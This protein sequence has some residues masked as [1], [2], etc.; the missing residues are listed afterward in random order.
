MREQETV[1]VEQ[2]RI[3]KDIEERVA[4][5]PIVVVPNPSPVKVGISGEI[6]R[7]AEEAIVAT[8]RLFVALPLFLTTA[9]EVLRKRLFLVTTSPVLVRTPVPALNTVLL[10]N[11]RLDELRGCPLVV[12]ASKLRSLKI[13][14]DILTMA[15]EFSVS[16]FKTMTSTDMFV[17]S[18]A[19]I[20]CSAAY[21]QS[22]NWQN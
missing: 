22:E 18:S 7:I 2:L 19:T 13:L 15:R 5:I 8:S 4:P 6:N 16:K 9:L 20:G 12:R 11:E 21:R 1:S 3:E 14:F 10:M 17:A